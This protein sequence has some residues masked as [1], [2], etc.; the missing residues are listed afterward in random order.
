MLKEGGY[1][2]HFVTKGYGGIE[3]INTLIQSWH[4]P[5]SVGDESLLLSEVS[6]TWIGLDRNKSFE[7]A[8]NKGAD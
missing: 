2:P 1:N 6:S 4:S 8:K 7:L 3:K 5:K